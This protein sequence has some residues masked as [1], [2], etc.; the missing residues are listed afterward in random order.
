MRI[1]VKFFSYELLKCLQKAVINETEKAILVI[2]L[3]FFVLFIGLFTTNCAGF[4]V[5]YVGD[6][7]LFQIKVNA[8]NI[9]ETTPARYLLK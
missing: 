6:V 7:I 4:S 8:S 2:F 5:F 3:Y 1:F 9:K